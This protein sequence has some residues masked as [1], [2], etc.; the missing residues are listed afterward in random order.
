MLKKTY[1]YQSMWRK[2]K[3][4]QGI[5]EPHTVILYGQ[6]DVPVLAPIMSKRDPF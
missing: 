1:M 2:D 6:Y 4:Q 3:M 5:K